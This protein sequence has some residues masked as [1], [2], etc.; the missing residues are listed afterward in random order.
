MGN[1]NRAILVFHAFGT[2]LGQMDL[3]I[4]LFSFRLEFLFVE[5]L[6]ERSF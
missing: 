6:I 2:A 1:Q 5:K 3:A 4:S